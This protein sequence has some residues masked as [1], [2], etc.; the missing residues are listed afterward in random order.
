MG[1][2]T[3]TFGPKTLYLKAKIISQEYVI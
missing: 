3:E 2:K 1:F